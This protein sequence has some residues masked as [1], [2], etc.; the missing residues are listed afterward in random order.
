[1][2]YVETNV[3]YFKKKQEFVQTFTEGMPLEEA[4]KLR[5]SFNDFFNREVRG[6]RYDL[7]EF[8][9]RLLVHLDNGNRFTIDLKGFASPRSNPIY[10]QILSERRIV[11]VKNFLE[12]YEDGRLK[13]YMDDGTLQYTTLPLGSTQ[14]DP[15]VVAQLDDR[16]NSI[17]NV[18][19][20]LERRVEVRSSEE[21]D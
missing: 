19:A 2:E 18:F 3:V 6:G 8:A 21:N 20:S 14:A 16:K 17:Y 9:K 12:R 10:N 5:R 7:E 11:A 13:A 1:M 4:F 15:R